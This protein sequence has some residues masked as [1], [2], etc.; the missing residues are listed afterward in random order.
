MTADELVMAGIEY[1]S[2]A[3]IKNEKVYYSL[4]VSGGS[5][6]GSYEWW[7]MTPDLF[8]YSGTTGDND[9]H[10][11]AVGGS[12]LRYGY[13][14]YDRTDYVTVVFRP[15]VSLKSTVLVTGGSGTGN[16]PYT[17]ANP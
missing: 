17:L 2:Y 10:M 13:M 15:V 5:A 12:N 9:A 6:T 8:Y 14:N 1:S 11:F 3:S 7:T 16:S 4:N